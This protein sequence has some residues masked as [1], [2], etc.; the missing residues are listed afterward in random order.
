MDQ[1]KLSNTQGNIFSLSLA[2][3][4][5]VYGDIGDSSGGSFGSGDESSTSSPEGGDLNGDEGDDSGYGDLDSGRET[6]STGSTSSG[7]GYEGGQGGDGSS[8]WTGSCNQYSFS[9]GSVSP[10]TVTAGGTYT[11]KCNYG[12][13]VNF[14]CVPTSAPSGNCSWTGWEGTSAV[15]SCVAGSESGTFPAYCETASGTSS[16]CCNS[17][18]SI[19]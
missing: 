17:S 1:H 11:K 19:H 7:G 9:Y 13:S 12:T 2:A 8:Y 4:G 15:F 5:V 10:T 6:G 18:N 16:N 14:D 3:L